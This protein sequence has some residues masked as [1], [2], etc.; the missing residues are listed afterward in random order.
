MNHIS[1]ELD[2]TYAMI[3]EPYNRTQTY[4]EELLTCMA[5]DTENY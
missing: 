4:S 1:I 2:D 5:W 3:K